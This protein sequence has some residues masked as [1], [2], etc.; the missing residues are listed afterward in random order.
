MM[1]GEAAALLWGVTLTT[2]ACLLLSSLL[3]GGLLP[4]FPTFGFGEA[5]RSPALLSLVLVG[6][7]LG[8]LLTAV[9]ELGH[10]IAAR[11]AGFRLLGLAVG[12]DSFSHEGGRWRYRRIA[13]NPDLAGWMLSLPSGGPHLRRRRALMVLGGPAANLALGALLAAALVV[14]WERDSG[15]GWVAFARFV[16]ALALWITLFMASSNLYPLNAAGG[17]PTDGWVLQHL[18]RG[19]PTVDRDL[20][21]QS[22][23]GLAH[24][25]THPRDFP[26]ELVAVATSVSDGSEA[27]AWAC[28]WGYYRAMAAGDLGLAAARLHRLLAAREHFPEANQ[29][30]LDLDM[31]HMSAIQGDVETGR[32][33]LERAGAVPADDPVRVRAEVSLALAAGDTSGVEVRV[34]EVLAAWAE[35]GTDKQS[36]DEAAWLGRVT[37]ALK[38]GEVPHGLDLWPGPVAGGSQGELSR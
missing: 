38:R 32:S 18:L 6:R 3:P 24:A 21:M 8:P 19:G 9:H 5:G 11:L 35:S 12:T 14:A 29:A 1:R 20:A 27:D 26:L 13:R 30:H 4:D 31:A 15:D 23:W 7:L 34:G 25:G 36:P 33:W 37:A 10:A 17:S 16:M 2:A 22:L 28:Y